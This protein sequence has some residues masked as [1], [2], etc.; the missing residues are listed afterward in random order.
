MLSKFNK[1]GQEITQTQATT[2]PL[3]AKITMLDVQSPKPK[4]SHSHGN[5]NNSRPKHLLDTCYLHSANW[6]LVQMAYF[7]NFMQVVEYAKYKQI[8]MKVSKNSFHCGC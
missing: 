8:E 7:V 2:V 6:A 1:T 3:R 5:T 4:F